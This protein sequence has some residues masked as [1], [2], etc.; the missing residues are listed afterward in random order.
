[1]AEKEES[2]GEPCELE[3]LRKPPQQHSEGSESYWKAVAITKRW[4]PTAAS[5][6]NLRPWKDPVDFKCAAR[7]QRWTWAELCLDALPGTW[8][9]WARVW[10]PVSKP[11]QCPASQVSPCK[12]K[13]TAQRRWSNVPCRRRVVDGAHRVRQNVQGRRVAL[14]PVNCSKG[15][16]VGGRAEGTDDRLHGQVHSKL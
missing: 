15:W 6:Q 13:R 14:S 1:M 10:G 2:A 3:L 12:Q 4:E 5:I 9:P 8:T 16:S 11:W 7:I